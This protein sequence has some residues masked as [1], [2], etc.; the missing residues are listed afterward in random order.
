MAN[1]ILGKESQDQRDILLQDILGTLNPSSHFL[2][3]VL[4]TLI[5]AHPCLHT[6]D[7][8]WITREIILSPRLPRVFRPTA[9]QPVLSLELHTAYHLVRSPSIS[10][11]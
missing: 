10:I 5:L 7:Q 4:D 9:R 8:R 11:D 6:I 2:I 3:P 1:L